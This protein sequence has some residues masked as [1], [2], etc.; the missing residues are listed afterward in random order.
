MILL[1]ITLAAACLFLAGRRPFLLSPTAI[2]FGYFALVFPISYLASYLFDLPSPLFSSPRAIAQG[3]IVFAFCQILLGL[4]AFCLGRFLIPAVKVHWPQIELIESR[5]APL[6]GISLLMAF[7]GG[8]LVIRQVGG[9]SALIENSGAIRSGGLRGLGAA[10][11]AVTGL[12]PTVAQFALMRAF[13]QKATHIWIV[14][15]VCVASCA[16]G[17]LFGFRGVILGMLLQVAA[18]CHVMT[19][20]TYRRQVVAVIGALALLVTALGYMRIMVTGQGEEVET[21]ISGNPSEAF[22]VIS[23]NSLTRTRGVENVITMSDYMEQSHFHYFLDNIQETATAAIPSFILPKDISL[24]EK[25]GTAVYSPYLMNV[26]IIED[27]Y[28]GVSYTLIAEGYWNLGLAGIVLV[29]L[30]WGYL[31]NVVEATASG[32]ASGYLRTIVYKT[33]VGAMVLFVEVPQLGINSILITLV[34]N[35]GVLAF[36]SVRVRLA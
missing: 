27:V 24:S 22:A 6:I 17:G 10:S 32:D 29:C 5:F 13:R 1:W 11:L 28:G 19:G 23:N 26:G 21:L 3:K 31:L 30:F 9:F 2:F 8:F 33:I 14:L 18:I 4:L 12:L 35:L 34:M 16:L 25:I 7:A 36:L 15:L 20:R